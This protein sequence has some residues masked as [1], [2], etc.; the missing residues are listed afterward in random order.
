M[1]V[2]LWECICEDMCVIDCES[3]CVRLFVC[4]YVWFWVC[5][6]YCECMFFFYFE[7]VNV[8]FWGWICEDMRVWLIVRLWG[9]MCEVVC[10]CLIVSVDVCLSVCMFDF[11]RWVFVCVFECVTVHVSENGYVWLWGCVFDCEDLCFWLWGGMCLIVGVCES[12]CVF[13]CE[14]VYVWL[15]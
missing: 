10:L 13:D 1:C 14:G 12:V 2:W 15:W 3:V 9:C 6:F 7:C 5:V 11:E 8:W 4:I